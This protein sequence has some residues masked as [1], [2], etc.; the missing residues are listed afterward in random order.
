MYSMTVTWF[1][2]KLYINHTGPSVS[3]GVEP[4][5]C[6][7]TKGVSTIASYHK[8]KLTHLFYMLSYCGL[9]ILDGKIH[10]KAGPGHEPYS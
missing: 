10:L 7:L 6:F 9:C 3:G 1:I 8:N 4:Q 5:A 2:Y